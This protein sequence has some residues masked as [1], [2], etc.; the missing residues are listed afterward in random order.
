MCI[1]EIRQTRFLCPRSFVLGWERLDTK[2]VLMHRGLHVGASRSF[3]NQALLARHA[4]VSIALLDEHPRPTLAPPVRLS[5]CGQNQQR[6]FCAP[7]STTNHKRWCECWISLDAL[8][9]AHDRHRNIVPRISRGGCGRLKQLE[10]SARTPLP[11][12]REFLSHGVGAPLLHRPWVVVQGLD[13]VH[14]GQSSCV[15]AFRYPPLER[16]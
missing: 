15:D 9:R 2:P 11:L 12:I 5:R 4:L 8:A 6:S 7:R 3:H 14:E 13:P 16:L 1:G 10:V